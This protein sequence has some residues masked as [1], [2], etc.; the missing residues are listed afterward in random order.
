MKKNI[1]LVLLACL[2]IVLIACNSAKS[3]TYVMDEAG[4]KSEM[5]IDYE[6]DDV[7]KVTQK[8]EMAIA[9][10]GLSKEEL[11]KEIKN[12]SEEQEEIDG[13]EFNFDVT[14]KNVIITTIITIADLGGEGLSGLIPELQD[15][16]LK[17]DDFIKSIEVQG[18]KEK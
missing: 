17:L 10:T 11:E 14:D 15:G 16:T 1:G 9:D 4:A 18:Y 12:E 6:K 7:T 3:V 13:V 2:A 5:V 8:T